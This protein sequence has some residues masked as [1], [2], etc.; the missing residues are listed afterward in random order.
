MYTFLDFTSQI[1]M[2]KYIYI[3]YIY[4]S[5]IERNCKNKNDK[6]Y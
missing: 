1:P 6:K 4:I 2:I 5:E 3:Y